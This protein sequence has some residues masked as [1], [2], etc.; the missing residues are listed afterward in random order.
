MQLILLL[1]FATAAFSQKPVFFT[2]E[3][4]GPCNDT[5]VPIS[6]QSV[7]STQTSVTLVEGNTINFKTTTA[8]PVR[9]VFELVATID[10]Q[11]SDK[12]K[13]ETLC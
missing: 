9:Q 7:G 6:C 4:L 3:Q 10:D 13:E 12:R 8:F 1:W 5:N 2:M 11:G